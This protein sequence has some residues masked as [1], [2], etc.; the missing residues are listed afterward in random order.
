[1]PKFLFGLVCG[2]VVAGVADM[3]HA[4]PI[5]WGP[6]LTEVRTFSD[7]LVVNGWQMTDYEKGLKFT[8]NPALSGKSFSVN[9][10]GTSPAYFQAFQTKQ[11]KKGLVTKERWGEVY[12]NKK[13]QLKVRWVRTPLNL[14]LGNPVVAAVGASLPT[15]GTLPSTGYG[16]SAPDQNLDLGVDAVLFQAANL[17]ATTTPPAGGFGTVQEGPSVDGAAP[18]PEPATMLLMGVGLVGLALMGRKKFNK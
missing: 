11:T 4:V 1:M 14:D 10:G 16:N 3:G 9:Y 12:Y 5:K 2:L 17:P 15:V 13:N 6:N 8:D 7:D 18:V